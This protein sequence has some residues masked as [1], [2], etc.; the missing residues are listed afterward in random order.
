METL[1]PPKRGHN[2]GHP[3]HQSIQ[4]TGPGALLK[5]KP[6]QLENNSAENVVGAPSS[7]L[8]PQSRLS[9]H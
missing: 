5:T 4:V 7:L 9:C 2:L 3:T 1:W 6:V 8:H